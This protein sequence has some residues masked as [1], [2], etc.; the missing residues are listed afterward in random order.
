M[1]KNSLKF[2][3]FIFLNLLLTNCLEKCLKVEGKKYF[4]SDETLTTYCGQEQTVFFNHL[5]VGEAIRFN[6]LFQSRQSDPCHTFG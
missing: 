4:F 1:L 2:N 6:I 3:G 5:T